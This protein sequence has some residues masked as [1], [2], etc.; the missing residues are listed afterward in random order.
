M[1]LLRACHFG[2]H[3]L[4][5]RRHQELAADAQI[6]CD[7]PRQNEKND[8]DDPDKRAQRQKPSRGAVKNRKR[9][10]GEPRHHQDERSLDE[11]AD[12]DRSPKYRQETEAGRF[13]AAPRRQ[14]DARQHAH[15]DNNREKQHGVGLGE[16]GFRAEYGR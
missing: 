8:P 14:I 13:A 11:D 10:G 15:G 3:I 6:D 5:D 12:G 7:K 9:R 4:A 16:P 2:K 1:R